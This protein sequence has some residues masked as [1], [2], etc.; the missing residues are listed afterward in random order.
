MIIKYIHQR[1]TDEGLK[2]FPAWF[3]QIKATISNFPGFVS[4]HYSK[5]A[6]D[7]QVIDFYIVFEDKNTMSGWGDSQENLTISRKLTPCWH[8]QWSARY[9]EF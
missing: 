5:D 2:Q 6:D 7:R 8:K 4:A 9:I 3:Q 1:L